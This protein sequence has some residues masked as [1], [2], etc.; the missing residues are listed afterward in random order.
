MTDETARHWNPP[1]DWEFVESVG[2][3]GEGTTYLAR[4]LETDRRAAIKQLTIDEHRDREELRQEAEYLEELEHPAIPEFIDFRREQTADDEETFYL[5]QEYVDGVS[6][7]DRIE[8]GERFSTEALW[9]LLEQLLEVLSHLHGRSPPLV[10][11]DVKPA[12]ILWTRDEEVRLVDFGAA[13]HPEQEQTGTAVVGTAGF[14]APEQFFGD[15]VPASDL[16]GAGATLLYAA[17]HRHPSEFPMEGL[18]LRIRNRVGAPPELTQFFERL[19][20]P[21]PGDRYEDAAAALEALEGTEPAPVER[22]QSG[23]RIEVVRT[24]DHLEIDLESR[25]PDRHRNSILRTLALG[26]LI[27]AAFLVTVGVKFPPI[28]FGLA[29]GLGT[30]LAM[31]GFQYL[32]K[33]GRARLVLEPS[34]WRLE[35]RGWFRSRVHEGDYSAG[36]DVLGHSNLR[37]VTLEGPVAELGWTPNPRDRERLHDAVRG[38]IE[39]RAEEGAPGETS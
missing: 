33:R 3:G 18:R 28:M 22:A 2:R 39:D 17:S 25:P 5:I 27:F 7:L 1:T 30:T 29:V 14:T 31:Q 37:L 36:L 9:D 32:R 24:P 15:A 6:L 23:E 16:Y 4:H 21:E 20:A 8:A 38:F 26:S 34:G 19:L 10:H 12:N 35:G 13:R 11:G